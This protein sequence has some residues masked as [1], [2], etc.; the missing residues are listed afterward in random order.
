[1]GCIEFFIEHAET[2]EVCKLLQEKSHDEILAWETE[3][4]SEF[5]P[6]PVLDEEILQRQ[7]ISPI[8][9]DHATQKLT[10]MAFDDASGKGLSVN[11]TDYDNET[12]LTDAGIARV[13]QY[14]LN[15]DRQREFWGLI[16]L[17]SS[18]VRAITVTT[19]DTAPVRGF[20]IYDTANE[21]S[22]SHAD[23]CQIVKKAQGRS[24]RSKLLD[25]GNQFIAAQTGGPPEFFTQS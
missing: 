2:K 23:I 18:E 17:V 9:F 21:T 19:P 6:G 3:T 4:A 10:A 14:N 12:H 11:R 15:N 25:L 13:Q 5:S 24:V 8:H 1:M 22:K 16:S 7:I 20:A